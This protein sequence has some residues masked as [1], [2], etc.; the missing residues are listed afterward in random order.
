MCLHIIKFLESIHSCVMR[1][2]FEIA[3]VIFE[4]TIIREPAT[5]VPLLLMARDTGTV[6]V[7][8]VIWVP[9]FFDPVGKSVYPTLSVSFVSKT[10][11]T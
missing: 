7:R 9:F 5:T 1:T 3:S 6:S 2:N 10:K 8:P 4:M 11:E